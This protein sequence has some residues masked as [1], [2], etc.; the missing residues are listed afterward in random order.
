MQHLDR[1]GPTR[2]VLLGLVDDAHPAHSEDAEDPVAPDPLGETQDLERRSIARGW[3]RWRD[4][5][6]A[7]TARVRG[8]QRGDLRTEVPIV[9][10][11]HVDEGRAL[12]GAELDRPHEHHARAAVELRVHGSFPAPSSRRRNARAMNQSPLTVPGET[13]STR[14][15]SSIESP[16]KKRISTTRAWRS[17]SSVS[18]SSK[19]SSARTSSGSDSVP[20]A[21]PSRVTRCQPPPRTEAARRRARSTSR[22]THATARTSSRGAR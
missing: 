20:N 18:F 1:Y 19:A 13:S 12:V 21:V 22:R 3:S 8:E 15:V 2:I 5:V 14:A 16:A 17:S 4:A 7:A 9:R 11:L 6:E 10:A